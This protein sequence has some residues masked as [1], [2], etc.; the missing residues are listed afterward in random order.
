MERTAWPPQF[1]TE[2]PTP[3]ATFPKPVRSPNPAP[4][5]ILNDVFAFQGLLNRIRRTIEPAVALVGRGAVR[6]R[7]PATGWTL[8]GLLLAV[9]SGGAYAGVLAGGQVLAGLL[10]LASGLVDMIDGSVARLTGTVSAKGAFLDS[11][12]DR[13][14]EIAVFL[15]LLVGQGV[16]PL[17]V[18]LALSFSMMVSYSRARGEALGVRMAGVGVGERAERILVLAA[19]SLLGV[20]EVGLMLVSGLAAVTF[21]H[22]VAHV[23][24]SGV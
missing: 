11:T 19:A 12:V 23:T 6:T 14:S 17:W 10:L 1:D 8:V 21:L 3:L 2:H 4:I 13:L 24:R 18:F 20:A 15:G 7:I 16:S 5:Y 22:R 9:L